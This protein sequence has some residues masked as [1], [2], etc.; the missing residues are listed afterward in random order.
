MLTSD[1]TAVQDIEEPALDGIELLN[2]LHEL[3]SVLDG[4]RRYTKLLTNGIPESNSL[5]MYAESVQTG[6]NRICG[7]QTEMLDLIKRE[8]L[9]LPTVVNTHAR[10]RQ[11]S[12]SS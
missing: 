12:G 4:T 7:I 10:T 1:H 8:F 9:L 5:R 11:I 2:M 6:L 3:A